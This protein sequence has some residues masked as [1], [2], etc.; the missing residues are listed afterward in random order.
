MPALVK[1]SQARQ[2]HS[3]QMGAIH[4]EELAGLQKDSP[5]CGPGILQLLFK[6]VASL[7][8]RRENT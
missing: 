1:G 4:L 2:A 5:H 8:R 6:P 3:E 7:L